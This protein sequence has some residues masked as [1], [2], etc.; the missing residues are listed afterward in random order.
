[1][2]V[3]LT[4]G[5]RAT[6]CNVNGGWSRREAAVDW[7]LGTE[8]LTQIDEYVCTAHFR[9]DDDDDDGD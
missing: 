8:H 6:I 3:G 2:N 9:D 1:M 7:M 4:Q 5:T